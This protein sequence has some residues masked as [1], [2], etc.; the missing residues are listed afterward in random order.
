MHEETH[1]PSLAK[2]ARGGKALARAG[3]AVDFLTAGLASRES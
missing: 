3:A 1:R 2:I